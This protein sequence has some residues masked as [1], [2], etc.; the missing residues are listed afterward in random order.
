[1]TKVVLEMD[2]TGAWDWKNPKLGKV[3]EEAA[4]NPLYRLMGR[5]NNSKAPSGCA[6]KRALKP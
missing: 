4:G 5:N 2:A 6:L 3:F 1:M